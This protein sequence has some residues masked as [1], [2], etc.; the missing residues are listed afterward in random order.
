M[1]GGQQSSATGKIEDICEALGVKKDHIHVVDPLPKH[2]DK[3]MEVFQKEI[4]YEGV[5]VIIPRR[6][7]IQTVARRLK[8]EKKIKE[9]HATK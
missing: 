4:A 7:C 8:I 2:H 9:M 6:E 3:N 1:T 5:S